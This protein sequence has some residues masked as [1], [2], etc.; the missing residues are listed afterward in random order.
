MM[1]KRL[2]ICGLYDT[3]AKDSPGT[4]VA[5]PGKLQTTAHWTAATLRALQVRQARAPPSPYKGLAKLTHWP[6]C[7]ATAKDPPED[8]GRSGLGTLSIGRRRGARCAHLRRRPRALRPP[9]AAPAR[10]APRRPPRPP[11]GAQARALAGQAS[12]RRALRVTV[13]AR[14]GLRPRRVAQMS[15]ADTYR[16]SPI[17]AYRASECQHQQHSPPHSTA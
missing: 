5:T 12:A 16:G 3:H 6:F 14:A 11:C 7:A 8:A 10:A 2:C 4:W 9:A 1:P 15:R 13:A 17:K